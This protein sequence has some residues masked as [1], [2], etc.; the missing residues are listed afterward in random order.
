MGTLVIA[1]LSSSVMF[2]ATFMSDIC[3]KL[4]L[5]LVYVAVRFIHL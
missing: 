4:L 1:N 3:I 5:I 2:Y